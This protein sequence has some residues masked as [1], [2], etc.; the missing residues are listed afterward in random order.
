MTTIAANRSE[1][2]ADSQATRDSGLIVSYSDRKVRR[3]GG[4]IVACQGA[5][6]QIAVFEEWYEDGRDPK[7]APAE[8]L[9]ENFAALVLTAGGRL[10]KWFRLCV[11]VEVHEP[12]IAIGAGDEIAMGAM[13]A[14]ATPERAVEIACR[15]NMYTGPPV[16]VERLAG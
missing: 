9:Q 15:L 12:F 3:I 13:A 8:D 6:D 5:E 1:M 16:V 11:P 14:G 7:Q 4:D 10:F 2:A